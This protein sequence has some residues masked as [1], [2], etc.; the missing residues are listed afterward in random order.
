MDNNASATYGA[1]VRHYR[2]RSQFTQERL[3]ELADVSRQTIG[4]IERG[5]T[6][7]SRSSVIVHLATALKLTDVE[8]KGLLDAPDS[9]PVDAPSLQSTQSLREQTIRELSTDI[10]KYV[11]YPDALKSL[12]GKVRSDRY[13]CDDDEAQ[14][15]TAYLAR[16]LTALGRPQEAMIR[17]HELFGDDRRLNGKKLTSHLLEAAAFA[18]YAVGRYDEVNIVAGRARDRAREEDENDVLVRTVRLAD[19]VA[20]ELREL[21][22]IVLESDAI[23]Q[24]RCPPITR[25]APVFISEHGWLFHADDEP[26]L[27]AVLAHVPDIHAERGEFDDSRV[28]ADRAV[29]CASR[30][31]DEMLVAALGP[32]RCASHL[33]TGAWRDAQVVMERCRIAQD[34]PHILDLNLYPLYCEGRILLLQGAWDEATVQLEHCLQDSP[35]TGFIHLARWCAR[36]LTEIALIRGQVE[37]LPVYIGHMELVLD[38][39]GVDEWDGIWLLPYLA[40]AYLETEDRYKAEAYVRDAI[41]RATKGRHTIALFDALRVRAMIETRWQ[42]WC[43]AEATLDEAFHLADNIGYTLGTARVERVYGDLYDAQ[44]QTRKARTHYNRAYLSFVGLSAFGERDRLPGRR[45][46][47]TP[48]TFNGA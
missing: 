25:L 24:L 43:Q 19:V 33:V 34:S 8:R 36:S 17:I 2:E 12:Q 14:R 4:D 38:R 31:G 6:R 32:T 37:A 41:G 27:C 9:V 18:L 40:W 35:W 28:A 16:T 3:A 23:L 45:P 5:K 13:F 20:R 47:S 21:Q 22:A 29:K 39:A 7:K 30:A 44:G 46:E 26:L 10:A 11:R 1:L 42:R 15:T 48:D